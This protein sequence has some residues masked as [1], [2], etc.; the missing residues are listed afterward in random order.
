MKDCPDY[1]LKINIK[2]MSK[3]IFKYSNS[4]LGWNEKPT[5]KE[6]GS[7]TN[8][9]KDFSSTI[10]EFLDNV[11]VPYAQSWSG[12]R[13]NGKICNENWIDQQVIGLDFDTGTKQPQEVIDYFT[14]YGIPPSI[15]YCTFSHQPDHPKFRI[16]FFLDEP[17]TCK[18]Q[19]KL[20]F[21][22][23]SYHLDV[24]TKC[25]NPARIFLGGTHG[26]II[27]NYPIS[28]KSFLETI[29]KMGED[30]CLDLD[31]T[32]TDKGDRKFSEQLY[33]NNSSTELITH[34]TTPIPRDQKIDLEILRNEVKVLDILF[35]GE[36]KLHHNEVFGLGTNM[37]YI[38]KGKTLML[39]LMKNYDRNNEKG[40]KP[41]NYA[42]LDCIMRMDYQP[43]PVKNFSAC[44]EDK[45]LDTL[46]DIAKKKGK[47]VVKEKATKIPLAEAEKILKEK[48]KYVIENKKE[49]HTVYIF[50][51]PTAIGKTKLL[52]NV[53]N[54]VIAEPTN[55]LKNEVKERMKSPSRMTPDPIEFIDDNINITVKSLYNIGLPKKA[56][57]IIYNVSEGHGSINDQEIAKTYITELKDCYSRKYNTL[58]THTRAINTNSENEF[59]HETIIFDEDPLDTLVKVD[60]T[61]VNDISAFQWQFEVLKEVTNYFKNLPNGIYNTPT[62]SFDLEE[63]VKNVRDGKG[64]STN[65]FQFFGSNSFI[66]KDGKIDYIMK[67][68]LP[69][70]KK[71]IIL[72]ATIDPDF[73][74]KI[75]PEY[76]FEVVDITHVEQIGK[77]IQYTGFSC[78]RLSLMKVA[79]NIQDQVQER[80]VITFKRYKKLFTNSVKDIHFGNCAGYDTL[81]GQDL[82][83]VGTPHIAPEKYYFLA[84]L[85]GVEFV[86]G[87]TPVNNQRVTYRGFEFTIKCFLNEELR[88]IQFSC[89]ESELL[90]AVGRGRTLRRDCTVEVYSNFPLYVSD[91]FHMK[92]VA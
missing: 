67:T 73:Y 74:R 91:E 57:E 2:N 32:G 80:K 7:I 27:N 63:L 88:K 30:Y 17:I 52:E 20:I 38:R 61:T 55:P 42:A 41:N 47:V 4:K 82:V 77:I 59:P 70:H 23:M 68:A 3:H 58:T 89:I 78:S 37:Q 19:L 18:I 25:F 50:R 87:E 46:L 10:E 86:Y 31:A 22:V 28:Q 43:M 56:M 48:F 81:A 13:F 8:T 49:D 39:E 90:Q 33:I 79:K 54:S 69:T 6:I 40:Y 24:D 45:E 71:V 92:K 85:M 51:L 44:D 65:V 1:K 60:S 14:G 62:F 11:T 84:K 15:Y 76:K 16:V 53:G 21:T 26:E 29:K 35:T 36:R 34:N 9:M 72:S 64:I 75:Y 83:V 12:G 5:K 66:Y